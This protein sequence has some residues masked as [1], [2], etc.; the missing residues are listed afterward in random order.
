[1]NWLAITV[2]LVMVG[3]IGGALCYV[4]QKEPWRK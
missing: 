2:V 4:V 3:V 1:M